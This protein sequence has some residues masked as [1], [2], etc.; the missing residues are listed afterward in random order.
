MHH[1]DGAWGVNST[2][3]HAQLERFA[4]YFSSV[5]NASA[6]LDLFAAEQAPVAGV[7]GEVETEI[8]DCDH[9]DCAHAECAELA[10]NDL[11][12]LTGIRSM[13]ELPPPRRRK[14]R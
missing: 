11:D 12:D 7:G 1:H 14:A 6:F 8:A 9:A 2:R 13:M 4:N 10:E 3:R 5:S